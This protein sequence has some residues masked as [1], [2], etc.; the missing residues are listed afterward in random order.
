MSFSDLENFKT[1][2]RSSVSVREGQ[3]VVLLCG[4]PPHSGGKIQRCCVDLA[5]QSKSVLSELWLHISHVESFNWQS[6]NS[7]RI[8]HDNCFIFFNQWRQQLTFS[9]C[10]A[11]WHGNMFLQIQILAHLYMGVF[12]GVM[13]SA[14]QNTQSIY[15]VCQPTPHSP[16][17]SKP[18]LH[19]PDIPWMSGTF[20]GNLCTSLFRTICFQTFPS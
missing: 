16:P 18:S 20:K 17:F 19:F 11:N 13:A 15:P 1:H 3:G 9:Q 2:R 4:P 14:N 10:C 5:K 6:L 12:V 7:Y 8:F